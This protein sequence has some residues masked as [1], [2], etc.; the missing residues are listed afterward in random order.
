MLLRSPRSAFLRCGRA[1]DDPRFA[2]YPVLPV[3]E[4][5]GFEAGAAAEPG[6]PDRRA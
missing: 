3:L 4:C 6:D 5:P 2:R 1:K